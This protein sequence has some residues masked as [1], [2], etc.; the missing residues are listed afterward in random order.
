MNSVKL[1]I[2]GECTDKKE[3]K[4]IEIERGEAIEFL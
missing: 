3:M 1:Q 2:I 4:V